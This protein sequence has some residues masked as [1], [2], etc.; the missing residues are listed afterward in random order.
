L[1]RF[2]CWIDP[3]L[4]SAAVVGGGIHI[5]GEESAQGKWLSK[6]GVKEWLVSKGDE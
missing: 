6:G 2:R 4:V 5:V 1:V 3:L